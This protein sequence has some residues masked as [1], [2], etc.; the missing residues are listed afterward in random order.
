ML[1]F[2][3][4]SAMVLVG[5]LSI[6]LIITCPIV[7]IYSRSNGETVLTEKNISDFA[8]PRGAFFFI[9]SF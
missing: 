7:F 4:G 5:L 2:L 6:I 3:I 9:A 1:S 8:P